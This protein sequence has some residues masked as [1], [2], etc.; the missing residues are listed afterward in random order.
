[1]IIRHEVIRNVG[2]F[3]QPQVLADFYNGLTPAVQSMVQPVEIAEGT[4]INW[5]L[6]TWGESTGD[7]HEDSWWVPTNFNEGELGIAVN[8]ITSVASG[9]VGRAF[10]LSFADVVRLSEEPGRGFSDVASRKAP[11]PS[12][13]L[14]SDWWWLR[15]AVPNMGPAWY[16]RI[17][18][19]MMHGHSPQ[20]FG[21]VR[22]A[23]IINQSN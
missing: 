14:G 5:W 13:E 18:G 21:G 3:E 23:L 16:I 10:A 6:V 7:G 12:S 1:M 2:F 15:T 22:P 11:N 19:G 20:A 17:G 8:D 4:V 9:G